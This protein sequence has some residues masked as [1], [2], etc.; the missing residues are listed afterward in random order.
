MLDAETK[1][2]LSSIA[3]IQQD[4]HELKYKYMHITVDNNIKV[5]KQLKDIQVRLMILE[6]ILKKH[7]GTDFVDDCDIVEKSPIM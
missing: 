1:Q 3:V 7:F 4:M 6:A 2:L 5:D